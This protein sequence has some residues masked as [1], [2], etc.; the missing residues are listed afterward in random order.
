[1]GLLG[2]NSFWVVKA[3]LSPLHDH[4]SP[5]VLGACRS[6]APG[7]AHCLA[8]SHLMGERSQPWF[9]FCGRHSRRRGRAGRRAASPAGRSS[10]IGARSSAGATTE[11]CIGEPH[12]ACGD[13]C[14]RKRRPAKA[15]RASVVYTTLSPCA[16]GSGAI[17]LYGIPSI[18]AG[19]DR[20]FVGAAVKLMSRGIAVEAHQEEECVAILREFLR[21]L[22][23]H[24][25]KGLVSRR[26]H[27][28]V[29]P[30][31]RV[32]GVM[33]PSM[34]RENSGRVRVE[35]WCHQ[36]EFLQVH[37]LGCPPADQ[38]ENAFRGTDGRVG[39]LDRVAPRN[40]LRNPTSCTYQRQ[41][42]WGRR[43]DL[44]SSKTL[45]GLPG[46]DQG[47]PR[48]ARTRGGGHSALEDGGTCSSLSRLGPRGVP[49]S[50][51]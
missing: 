13:G 32:G 46:V 22:P 3:A 25:N 12:S 44:Q 6:D 15:Y 1:M 30:L 28:G 18:V 37:S 19:E 41:G 51:G 31:D 27:P 50:N 26:R 24:W 33:C 16:M 17:V 36:G 21:A 10:C 39:G 4:R 48:H 14:A 45:Q 29:G 35:S 5:P 2:E 43:V 8:P 7:C 49:L 40:S 47:G 23:D 42:S 34:Y 11:G 38:A 20:S 9:H